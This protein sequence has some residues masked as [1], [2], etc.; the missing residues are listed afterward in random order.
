MTYIDPEDSATLTPTNL[1]PL[2][3]TQ[4][5][6]LCSDGA[7]PCDFYTERLIWMKR[8]QGCD[9]ESGVSETGRPK[10]AKKEWDMSVN[11]VQKR[12]PL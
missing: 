7:L 9:W 4:T 2:C 5:R 12:H 8:A 10:T 1:F 11:A 3:H 6:I